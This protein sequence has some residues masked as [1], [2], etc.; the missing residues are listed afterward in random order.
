MKA[1]VLTNMD[2]RRSSAKPFFKILPCYVTDLSLVVH[3]HLNRWFLTAEGL[4][5]AAT[6]GTLHKF[7]Y[8]I[9]L[10]HAYANPVY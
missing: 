2:R 1:I 10:L 8:T 5:I 3:T 6:V 9:Y 7:G 4:E